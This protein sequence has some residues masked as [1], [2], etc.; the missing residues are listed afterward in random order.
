MM[1]SLLCHAERLKKRATFTLEQRN[2]AQSD[3]K[4]LYLELVENN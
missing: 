3:E 1:Y 2:M 4:G